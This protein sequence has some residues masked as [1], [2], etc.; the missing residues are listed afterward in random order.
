MIK[1]SHKAKLALDSGRIIQKLKTRE[2]L[3]KKANELLKNGDL[4]SI[5]GVA[6]AAGISKATAYRYFTTVEALVREASLQLKASNKADIFAG[7][8]SMD[9]EN[10]LLR[11]IDYHFKLFT[12]N[13][14]EFRLFLSA[15]IGD[16]V[17]NEE[18]PSRG[19]RRI[20]LIIEALA[21]IRNKVASEEFQQLVYSL[22]L[23]FGIESITIL[24]DLCR[25][26]N[27]AILKNWKWTVTQLVKP[28]LHL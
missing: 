6:Q 22:T 16:S 18:R 3:V 4:I 7:V 20:E 1:K 10:R 5:S 26:D 17:K 23:V 19:G 21:P 14:Q 25:L 9:L 11:L 15:V 2:A 28:F 13:E 8:D 24:R 27:D 12:E